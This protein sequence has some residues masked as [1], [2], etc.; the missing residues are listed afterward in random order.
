MYEILKAG[1]F[2]TGGLNFDSKQ[3]RGSFTLE[4]TAL[5]HIAGMDGFA[6]GL[7]LADRMI[8]DGR[9]DKFLDERYAS[10]KTG[11]GKSIIDGNESL[12]SLYAYVQKMGEVTTNISGRQEELEAIVNQC[13][14]SI[15]Y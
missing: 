13:L 11:I 1:G 6:L 2:T 7:L 3:R 4:D 12:E 10:W 8:E 15:E 5:A 9:I 14:M